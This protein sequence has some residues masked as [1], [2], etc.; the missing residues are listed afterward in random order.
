MLSLTACIKLL[1]HSW[2]TPMPKWEKDVE[3][4][5]RSSTPGSLVISV[6]SIFMIRRRRIRSLSF[7][8]FV[9]KRECIQLRHVITIEKRPR[10]IGIKRSRRKAHERI[11][12]C[13]TRLA[14][15]LLA[16]Y[17]SAGDRKQRS[18]AGVERRVST[19]Q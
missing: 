7:R 12:S 16:R 8:L 14:E 9:E 5:C 10:S 19:E 17:A 1:F 3:V 11:E 18:R 4:I 2:I 13:S 6:V 15:S